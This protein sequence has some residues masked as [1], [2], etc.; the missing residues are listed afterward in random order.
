MA[1][2]KR[3]DGTGSIGHIQGSPNFYIWYRVNGRQV[4]ESSSSTDYG[5]AEKLLQRRM[6]EE[7]L[8]LK[9]AQ[10]VKNLRYEDVRGSY[11]EAFK[12]EKK[13]KGIIQRTDGT[14]TVRGLEQIDKY[15][16]GM[17]VTAITSD[18]IR[19]YIKTRSAA[20][21]TGPTIRR[22]LIVLRAILNRA[23]KEDKLSKADV[24]YFTM[25]PDS[26]AAGKYIS[27]K[28][29][30]LIRENLPKNLRPFFTFLYGTSCRL[31]AARKIT[32]RML[33]KDRTVIEL[34]AA[35]IKNKTPLTIVLAGG[36]L[37]PLAKELK[38]TF[39]APDDKPVFDSTN[40]RTGW[41]RAVAAAKI[42]T[43]EEKT[44]KR[45]G[46][47]IHDCRV[48]AAKN[49]IDGGEAQDVVM[50]IGGWKTTSTFSRYNLLDAAGVRKAMKKSGDAVMERM[51][52]TD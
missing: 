5:V 41:N 52:G 1:K 12:I 47:R 50:K 11:L 43:F 39:S 6:G 9:P 30:D 27:P 40:Y 28:E 49:L 15:F 35:I 29:F 44:R 4:R 3:A 26:E 20:G 48:S 25:P 37:E 22:E 46:V 21:V 13:G 19:R 2:K 24:P 31:G 45:T 16:A 42:G 8:G 14:E 51:N 23:K 38:A 10:D 33:S 18:E 34:P 36:L 32:W 17:R 7:G